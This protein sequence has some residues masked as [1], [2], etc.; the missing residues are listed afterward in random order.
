MNKNDEISKIKLDVDN[1]WD[2]NSPIYQIVEYIVR[3]C[4]NKRFKKKHD[5]VHSEFSKKKQL[6]EEKYVEI[7]EEISREKNEFVTDVKSSIKNFIKSI[8]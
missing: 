1:N 6:L 4:I 8:F 5:K 7:Q 3:I 2:F